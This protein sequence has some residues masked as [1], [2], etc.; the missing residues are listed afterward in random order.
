MSYQQYRESKSFTELVE[1]VLDD[2]IGKSEE[3]SE[4]SIEIAK[5]RFKALLSIVMLAHMDITKQNQERGVKLLAAGRIN[6]PE[7]KEATEIAE[8]WDRSVNVFSMKSIM[9]DLL[10]SVPEDRPTPS[11]VFE[12]AME[13]TRT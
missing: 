13:K 5:S 9:Q 3:H 6:G 8:K 2:T 1:R 4:E 12:D 10:V 7:M 11:D